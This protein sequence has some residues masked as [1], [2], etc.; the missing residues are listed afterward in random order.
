MSHIQALLQPTKEHKMM[1]NDFN[2]H[3][4]NGGVTIAA[5]IDGIQMFK[6]PEKVMAT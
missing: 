3:K 1:V 5:T 6:P 4:S 2:W